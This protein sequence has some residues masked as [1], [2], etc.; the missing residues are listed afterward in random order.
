MSYGF[1][2]VLT[3][4]LNIALFHVLVSFQMNYKYA[5]FVTLVVVKL[6]AYLCNKNFVFHS[7]TGSV[8]ELAKEFGRFL[9]ARGITMIIDYIGLIFMVDVLTLNKLYSKC[10]VTILVIIIN[11][12]VGKKHVFKQA[13]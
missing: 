6:I 4:C 13:V 11:Y 7:K 8:I 3:S 5:N 9:I 12:F 10:F 1:F 2:G